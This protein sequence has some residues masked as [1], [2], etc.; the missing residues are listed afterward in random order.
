MSDRSEPVALS[1]FSALRAEYDM[2][3]RTELYPYLKTQESVRLKYLKRFYGLLFGAAILIPLLCLLAYQIS[4]VRGFQIDWNYVWILIAIAIYV[5]RGPYKAYNAEVKTETTKR[6]IEFFKGFSYH[7]GE[8]LSAM[9]LKNSR[10]FP[11]FDR[12]T[13]DDCFVGRFEGVGLNVSEYH[14]ERLEHHDKSTHYVTVFRGIAVEFELPKSYQGRT[15]VL[16]DAGIF[17]VFHHE[18]GLQRIKL[19]DVVFEK[20]FEVYASDQ[21]EARYLLTTAFMERLLKLCS[22]YDGKSI[23]ALFEGNKLLLAVNTGKDMFEPCSFFRTN[24][25]RDKID[26]FFS[27]IV[28]IFEM[29]RILKLQRP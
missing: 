8:G 22:L 15:L 5:V 7:R 19:E 14:L 11:S 17:N 9:E 29:V 16:A 6:L 2:F 13:T 1:D 3:C 10:I 26:L 18:R 21:I 24:L 20:E 12:M 28:T 25:R 27:Q 4:V 23:Q